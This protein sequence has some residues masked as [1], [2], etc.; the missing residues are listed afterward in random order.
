MSRPGPALA[1][2]SL[3]T[4]S[5]AL[6]GFLIGALGVQL[7]ED[8]GFGRG[9]LG[10]A[11]A[12]F[13]AAAACF[14]FVGGR[15]AERHGPDR[16]LRATLAGSFAGYFAV[17][18][19]AA[20]PLSLC[21]LAALCG[22]AN[23]LTQPGVNTL[24]FRAV[25]ADRL[26]VAFAVKQSAIPATTLIGGVSVPLFGET[27]GWRWAFAVFGLLPLIAWSLLPRLEVRSAPVRTVMSDGA[28]RWRSLG[29]LAV[30]I[31]LGAA[32]TGALGAFFVSSAVDFGIGRSAAGWLAAA[33]SATC[34]AVRLIVG[35]R[36][37]RSGA[38]PLRLCASM[39]LIGAAANAVIA[40]GTPTA[41]VA[42]TA[43]VFG[44]GWGWAGLFNLA[45]VRLNPDAPGVATGITQTG[46]YVGAGAGP[47]L[48]GWIADNFSTERAWVAAAS[49]ALV[50]AAAILVGGRLA[51][52]GRL[53]ATDM[54]STMR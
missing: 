20:G 46:T 50:A 51:R 29:F 25:P 24:I 53:A 10:A 52:G 28:P 47:L 35:R 42:M 32:A 26:G 5:A 48:F 16:T 49:L 22:V 19:F 43:V 8:L 36:I 45:I 21:V 1:I 23:G 3:T 31:G 13:F 41:I 18:L 39:L 6:P 54:V 40:L 30:G 34:I 37:D 33:G 14:S 44:V 9:T 2:T 38:D 4:T 27:I 12:A 11:V 7:R 17:A 15:A